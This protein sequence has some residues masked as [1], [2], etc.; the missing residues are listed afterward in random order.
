MVRLKIFFQD[1]FTRPYPTLLQK[2]K[3]RIISKFQK[4]DTDPMIPFKPTIE[5]NSEGAFLVEHPAETLRKGTFSQVPWIVGLNSNDG[6]LRAAGIFGNPHL[7]DELDEKFKE[8][9]PISLLYDETSPKINEVTSQIR[10]FY[11]GTSKI[12]KNSRSEVV[13]VSYP[14]SM[15]LS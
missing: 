13:D 9:V 5:P 15:V 14:K 3:T 8:V 11:F 12:D 7:I 4:W 10:N 6:A 2:T 1:R